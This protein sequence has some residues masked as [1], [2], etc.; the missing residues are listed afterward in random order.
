MHDKYTNS[1]KN[2][3]LA[4]KL[5]K[6]LVLNISGFTVLSTFYLNVVIL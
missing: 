4:F 1:N 2:S 6:F 3:K 5:Q